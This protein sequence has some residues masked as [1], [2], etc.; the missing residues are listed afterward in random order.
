MAPSRKPDSV[1]LI[2]G[3]ISAQTE[4]FRRVEEPLVRRFGPVDVVSE[5]Y[6]FDMT[7]YYDA[8]TG[9]PLWRKFLAFETLV[10]PGDLHEIKRW[11]NELEIQLA[12]DAATTVPRPIN[13]DPG[14][15]APSKLILASMKDFAHRIYLRDG[16]YAE[17]TMQYR[18]GW[19]SLGWTFPD[20]ASGRYDAFLTATRTRLQE[21]QTAEPR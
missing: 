3:M 13:L 2:C 4:W 6:P 21:Q 16:V 7:T 14:Y 8:E 18:Q 11:T 1:K 5:V 19:C 10:A 12:A 9:S 15:I 17:V 20:F